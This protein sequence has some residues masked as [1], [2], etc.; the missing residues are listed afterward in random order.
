MPTWLTVLYLI[1]VGDYGTVNE[2]TGEFDIEG[3]VYNE[4]PDQKELNPPIVG[5]PEDS[6]VA[7]SKEV[8][9][10]EI[11]PKSDL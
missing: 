11:D 2:D 10:N 4:F 8:A 7:N 1:K 9:R 3:N 6:Y 5:K